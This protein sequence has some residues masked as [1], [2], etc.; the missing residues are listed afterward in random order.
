[1]LLEATQLC[2]PS[3]TMA[4]CAASVE[5]TQTNRACHCDICYY[6]SLPT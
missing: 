1:V 3:N 4:E 2:L 5:D 6:S